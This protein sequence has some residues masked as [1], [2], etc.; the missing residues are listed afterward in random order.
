MNV[1][2]WMR[3]ARYTKA[4]CGDGVYAVR[5]YRPLGEEGEPAEEGVT[6]EKL[7]A[8][9]EEM[10]S[11]VVVETVSE[12][13]RRAKEHLCNLLRSDPRKD[14]ASIG[15]MSF[16]VGRVGSAHKG[17]HMD[18][19]ICEP[20]MNGGHVGL[21]PPHAVWSE[22]PYSGIDPMWDTEEV[23]APPRK[24]KRETKGKPEVKGKEP[25]VKEKDTSK[26]S[27]ATP[28]EHKIIGSQL[29]RPYPLGS[30]VCLY[31]DV[32][33]ASGSRIGAAFEVVEKDTPSWR[34]SAIRKICS[35]FIVHEVSADW[36][37]EQ[38]EYPLRLHTQKRLT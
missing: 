5:N 36:I 13:H 3:Y 16:H 11:E 30:K 9:W 37:L 14:Y 31:L 19:P 20:S 26:V 7:M 28:P 1:D 4:T 2:E 29:A 27:E 34:Y 32:V 15:M 6:K 25:E 33:V 23:M 38:K 10:P 17:V 22:K 8:L 21:L 12:K 18:Y 24:R 35:G